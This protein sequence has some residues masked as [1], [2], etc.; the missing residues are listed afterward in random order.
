LPQALQSQTY[1]GQRHG[2]RANAHWVKEDLRGG[3]DTPGK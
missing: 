2:V 1:S 3:K